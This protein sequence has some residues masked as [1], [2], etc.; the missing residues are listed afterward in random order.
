[1][2]YTK[3]NL[4]AP[5]YELQEKETERQ[6]Y[7][8]NIFCNTDMQISEFAKSFDGAKKGTDCKL[9]GDYIHLEF[10]PPKIATFKKWYTFCQ[11]KTRKREYWKCKLN[12]IRD[13]LQKDLVEFFKEDSRKLRK[14]AKRDWVLDDE[15]D[16][17]DKTPPH[18]KSKGKND[19]ATAHQKKIDTLLIESGMPS[20]ITQSDVNMNANITGEVEI[21]K[22]FFEDK[23]AYNTDDVKDM[24]FKEDDE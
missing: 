3:L 1:M 12:N 2:A 8:F 9:E 23:P 15:I 14:S 16:Y 20:D 19:L 10:N 5:I 22:D 17:D 11:W 4:V 13:E 21:T 7:F 18:L 24:L 6:Y